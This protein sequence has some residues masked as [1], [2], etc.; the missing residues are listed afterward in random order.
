MY[1]KPT[2]FLWSKIE[3]KIN[4]MFEERIKFASNWY[5]YGTTQSQFNRLCIANLIPPEID[6]QIQALGERWFPQ[7]DNVSVLI[8]NGMAK[9]N[10]M[11][12]MAIGG[13]KPFVSPHWNAYH[14]QGH[15]KV[16]DEVIEGI[17]RRRR[18][19]L[20]KVMTEKKEFVDQVKKVWD[21][22]PSINALAKI[23]PPIT[24]LLPPDIVEKL[25][26]KPKRRT[27]KQLAQDMD[28]KSLSVSI[29]KA[30]VAQ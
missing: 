24:D 7:N 22:A 29:L 20:A 27:T 25:E 13:R 3:N 6:A 18:E 15:P 21:E 16:D 5:N 9:D 14:S 8:H 2:Q 12:P 28:T 26:T 17:A 23:W 4:S 1:L 30:K 19:A 11:L 10:Y